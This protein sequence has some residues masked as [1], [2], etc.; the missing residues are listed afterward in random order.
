VTAK[1]GQIEL[2]GDVYRWIYVQYGDMPGFDV[3]SQLFPLATREGYERIFLPKLC[4]IAER[5]E[6]RRLTKRLNSI[7]QR[8]RWHYR[9]NESDDGTITAESVIALLK[10][11]DFCCTICAAYLTKSA[12]KQLDHVKPLSKGGRHTLSNVQWLCRTCNISKG[13]KY[14]SAQ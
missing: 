7:R 6:R 11:Q 3:V 12:H 4:L 8:M 10:S 5:Y 1:N 14:E 2:V 13:A 9:R